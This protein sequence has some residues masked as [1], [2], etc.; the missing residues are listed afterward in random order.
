MLDLPELSGPSFHTV[1]EPEPEVQRSGATSAAPPSASTPQRARP[2]TSP[3]PAP[4]SSPRAS[5]LSQSSEE[6]R[7][8]SRFAPLTGWSPLP[9]APQSVG[10][11]G[12]PLLGRVS[13]RPL[14]TT[15]HPRRP[16]LLKRRRAHR[17]VTGRPPVST[18]RI[19]ARRCRRRPC[20]RGPR[21]VPASPT[22]DFGPEGPPPQIRSADPCA[23]C[24]VSNAP[25]K[26]STLKPSWP[27]IPKDRLTA[28]APP[29][30]GIRRSSSSM[31]MASPASQ[32]LA[33]SRL[34][35][36][37]PEGPHKRGST[38]RDVSTCS[39]LPCPE[40]LGSRARAE[41]RRPWS[42]PRPAALITPEGASSRC[43]CPRPR[44]ALD[45]SVGPGRRPD[46]AL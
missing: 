33:K 21:P 41:R 46:S 35:S 13:A 32:G 2:R 30:I 23:L 8:R 17:V 5:F 18:V 40:G 37:R 29:T 43:R 6:L 31:G 25:P 19:C 9:R 34:L 4:S 1:I 7:E 38:A 26:R 3:H 11:K 16:P 39:P 20:P 42:S 14:V 45:P 27:R 24:R 12:P 28:L 44:K 10:P 22:C 36:L 15:R